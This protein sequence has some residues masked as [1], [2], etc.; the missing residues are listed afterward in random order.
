[1]IPYQNGSR[2]VTAIR[3][4]TWNKIA[5]AV[6][7]QQL[8]QGSSP[9]H[10]LAGVGTQW[11]WI[12]NTGTDRLQFECS[13]LDLD[14]APVLDIAPDG[15]RHPVLTAVDDDNPELTT[16]IWQEPAKANTIAR[17]VISG[18]SLALVQPSTETTR[19]VSRSGNSL[20]IDAAGAILLLMRPLDDEDKLLLVDLSPGGSGGATL[21][22]FR[23][24]ED[25]SGTIAYGRKCRWD[26]TG[27]TGDP[28][29]IRNWDGLLDGALEGY[30]FLAGRVETDGELEWAFVQGRC[31]GESGGGALSIP[32]SLIVGL[33]M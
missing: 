33:G 3:P 7:G 12:R 1:M 5:E 4:Q 14:A 16:V 11:V 26:G 10:P 32:F 27:E 15:N 19:L 18:L 28:L 29:E 6:N 8:G 25:V 17:A 24:T 2:N 23:L 9:S 31:I 13:G 30:K 21:Q 22:F 20:A